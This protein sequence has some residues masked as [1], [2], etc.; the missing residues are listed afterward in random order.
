MPNLPSQIRKF[1]RQELHGTY[2]I[3]FA[4]IEALEGD[5]RDNVGRAG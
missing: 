3:T 5:R 2:T 1:V 4:I